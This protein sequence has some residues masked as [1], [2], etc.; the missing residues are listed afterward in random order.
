MLIAQLSDLHIRVSGQKLYDH[1]DT[2]T[3]CARHVAYINALPE[4]PDA[5]VLSGDITNCGEPGEYSMAR[6]I[7]KQIDFPTFVIPGNHDNNH[8]MIAALGQCFPH[9]G[10]D[11]D[12]IAYTVEDFP[13]RLVFL[14]SSSHGKVNG[15]L[16]SNTLSWLEKTLRQKPTQ[17]T[18]IFMHHHPLPTGCLHMD[19]IRCMDGIKLIGL[20][21]EFPQVI[22]IICGHTHRAIFH[23]ANGLI[24]CTAPSAA[25][26]IPFDTTD[27]RGSYS[28][29]PPAMLMHRYTVETG[30][31][32][33]VMSLAPHDGPFRFDTTCGCPQE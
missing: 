1:I 22:R 20:V 11:P 32:S 12:N 21:K 19:T 6:R 26:Q 18:A 3:L 15:N 9:L 4:P 13:I 31:V 27:S 25:H 30:F 24:I 17:Q 2:N 29:E 28:L 5:V 16:G 23:Q 10:N 7:L 14:D 8:N 33:Y